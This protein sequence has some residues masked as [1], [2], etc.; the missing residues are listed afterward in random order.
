MTGVLDLKALAPSGVAFRPVTEYEA[1]LARR[2][3]IWKPQ[4]GPQAAAYSSSANVIGYGGAAGG[5]KS[6]L[7]IGLAV[8]QH[9]RSII[10]R[11]EGDQTRGLFRRAKEIVGDRGRI[12]HTLRLISELPGDR[13]VEFN[14][15]KNLDDWNRYRGV[16]RDLMVFDEA[17]EFERE[18]VTSLMAWNR[19]TI[20]GQRCRVVL[21]FNPPGAKKGQWIMEFF[22]PWLDPKHPRPA[23]PGE[24]RWFTTIGGEDREVSDEN[25]VEVSRGGDRVTPRCAAPIDSGGRCAACGLE[26]VYP[27]SRTFIPARLDDNAFLTRDPQYRATLM[28]LPEPLRSQLLYGDF[29][30]AASDD[31]WQIIPTR[32]VQLAQE[33]WLE[34]PQPE[35][36][37]S[38]LGS[39]VA[40]GGDDRTT[41]APRIGNW[42]G[43]VDAVPGKLTPDGAAVIARLHHV[44]NQYAIGG[45]VPVGM[46]TVGVGSSPLDIAR[47]LGIH[48]L[49]INVAEAADENA[50]DRTGM[51]HFANR[52]AQLWW[53]FREA[54][55]P[56]K[57][58]AIALPPDRELLVDLCSAHYEI[59]LRGIKV[60]DKD[61]IRK[62]IGRS[63]DKGE[64][65][66]NCWA[67]RPSPVGYISVAKRHGM[68]SVMRHAAR[69]TSAAWKRQKGF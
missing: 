58:A 3:A 68:A 28:A 60:E 29:N 2:I 65:V 39:D 59:G 32:W 27:L 48:V 62:R 1:E 42:F 18:M 9:R 51:L 31:P 54:L 24:I 16:P 66:I 63:P 43:E 44:A 61:A 20:S 67:A 37:L 33:R 14:G 64:A 38:A 55:D 45:R 57:G 34:Q 53:G 13:E 8:T 69:E 11:R 23:D 4:P 52:R 26:V 25:P 46:D 17:T 56:E 49:P 41:T 21:P 10:F 22:G 40:R 12:N 50:T 35:G 5:G 30:A 36:P 47:E 7:A 19:T 15:I 6:D